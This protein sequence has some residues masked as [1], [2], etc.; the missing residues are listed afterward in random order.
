[1]QIPISQQRCNVQKCQTLQ[2]GAMLGW[3]AENEE[4][5]EEEEAAYDRRKVGDN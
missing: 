2:E 5:E 3:R 4:E 1:M